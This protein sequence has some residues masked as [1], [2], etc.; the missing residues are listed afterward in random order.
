LR[1]PPHLA[2]L[3]LPPVPQQLYPRDQQHEQRLAGKTAL[4]KKTET[5]SEQVRKID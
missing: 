1:C 4:V 3:H 2:Q 5:K